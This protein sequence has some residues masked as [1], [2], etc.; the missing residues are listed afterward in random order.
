MPLKQIESLLEKF[1]DLASGPIA[2]EAESVDREAR[3]PVQGMR[4]IQEAGLAGLVAPQESGGLGQGLY[5]LAR[6]CEIIGQESGSTAICY[7]MH[8]VATAVMAAKATPD[9][10]ERFLVPI[11]QG[12]HI[13]TLALSEP[14][15]GSHFYIPETALV[16]TSTPSYQ[17]SGTKSFVTNGGFADSY[18]ISTATADPG[19]PLGQFS[20]VI[21]PEHATGLTWSEPWNGLGMRGNSS[22]NLELKNVQVPAANLLG[23]FGDQIWYVFE[24]ITPYF[25]IAMAGS[26]LGLATAAFEE[27]SSHLKQRRHSHSGSALSES[28]LIQHRLGGLWVKLERARRLIYHAAWTGDSGSPD[29]LLPIFSAKVEISECVVEIANE[30]MT[31]MGG[32]AYGEN[33]KAARILRDAR[34]SHVMSPTTEI[35]KTWVGRSI[36]GKPLLGMDV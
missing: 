10:I 23:Q 18:V 17:I 20:L 5:T 25:L 7:G 11:S 3:W 36:L 14:G 15:S 6:A 27:A 31:L 35:L 29:S 2:S 22:R 8:S 16:S 30:A 19:T 26:Y 28:Q 21:V 32:I 1:Q 13:T 12:K 33:T 9:Q 24:I 34:A 4:A